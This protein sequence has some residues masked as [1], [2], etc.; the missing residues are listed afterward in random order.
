MRVLIIG[1][2][3]FMGPFA[4][5]ELVQAGHEVAVFHRG[6]SEPELPPGV[7][8]FHGDRTRLREHAETLRAYAPDVVLDMMLITQAEAEALMDTFRGVAQRVV[9]ASSCD[10]YRAY[11]RLRGVEPGPPDPTPLTEE[12]PLR[13]KLYPYHGEEPRA[14][15]DPQQ[16]LDDYDKILVERVVLGD[17]ALPG[18]VVRLPAVFGPHDYQHR[19]WSY[20]KRMDD[21]RPAIIFQDGYDAWRFGYGYVEDMGHALALAVMDARAAG[22]IYNVGR[23]DAWTQADVIRLLAAQ[24]GWQGDIVTVPADKLPENMREAANVAQHM[25]VDSGRIRAE[26]GYDEMVETAV[27][28]QR[29]IAYHRA[30]PPEQTADPFDY[31]A[32]DAI[33]TDLTTV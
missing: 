25:N 21:H 8:V 31:E 4:V 15:D 22:R 33:L 17:A 10:V 19:F 30:H 20:I 5:R 32:E 24:V 14:D 28:L 1:G 29:T 27:A 9:A 2:T 13:E 23:Q 12:S 3:R 16:R 18:T 26:L 11:N 6:R 7:R